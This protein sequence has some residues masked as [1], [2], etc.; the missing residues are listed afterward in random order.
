MNYFQGYDIESRRKAKMNSDDR[1]F[2]LKPM[3]GKPTL[4]SSGMVDNRLFTG[5]NKLHAI[6]DYQ[7][8]TWTI[9]FDLGGPPEAL[10]NQRFTHFSDLLAF[11]KKYYKSRNVDVVEAV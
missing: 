3:E 6:Y 11:V 9:K 2:V 5:E 10:K 4:S 8:G 1:I 7:R